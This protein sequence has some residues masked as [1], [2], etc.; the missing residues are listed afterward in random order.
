MTLLR[1][2]MIRYSAE[3]KSLM[4]TWNAGTEVVSHCLPQAHGNSGS[5]NLSA[6]C[7]PIN[8]RNSAS[9]LEKGKMDYWQPW[10]G[11][12]LYPLVGTSV[13]HTALRSLVWSVLKQVIPP[14]CS[15][16]S[17]IQSVSHLW[18]WR[19]PHRVGR[20][21]GSRWKRTLPSE[22]TDHIDTDCWE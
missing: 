11:F 21:K 15:S 12:D 5:A 13:I 17:L 6:I 20:R 19:L 8:R 14:P 18:A 16:K 9:L 2:M 4:V 7:L 3:G 1:L 10:S 22:G